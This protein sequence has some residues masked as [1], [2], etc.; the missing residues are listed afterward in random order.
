[1]YSHS[2]INH[3]ITFYP[4]HTNI[5]DSN[6]TLL[7]DFKKG[8]QYAIDHFFYEVYAWLLD[9]IPNGFVL[10]PIPSSNHKKTNQIT[11]LIKLLCKN[12]NYI[13][14][15]SFIIKRYKTPSICY[16]RYK[17]FNEKFNKSFYINQESV[18]NQNILLIDDIATSGNSMNIIA[19]Q[20]DLLN[21]SIIIKLVLGRTSYPK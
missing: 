11:K 2:P 5:A 15:S 6:R 3:L 4:K 14:G 13:D 19:S 10:I 16:S 17:R 18:L 7:M 20:L 21:A 9:C 12:G 8:K 1:M